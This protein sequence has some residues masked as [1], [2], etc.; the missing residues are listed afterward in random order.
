MLADL[1]WGLPIGSIVVPFL[2][3]PYRILNMNPQKNYIGK[4][5]HGAMSETEV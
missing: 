4:S 5:L 1:V 2:G 3:L